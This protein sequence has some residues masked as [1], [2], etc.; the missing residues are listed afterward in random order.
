MFVI[1]IRN[2]CTM[3]LLLSVRQIRGLIIEGRSTPGRIT[4]EEEKNGGGGGRVSLVPGPFLVPC[5]FQGVGYLWSHVPR[6]R[7]FLLGGG[8]G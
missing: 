8:V 2:L 1:K 3:Y 5:P 6:T 4:H 7:S